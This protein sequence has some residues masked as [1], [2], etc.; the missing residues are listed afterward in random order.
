MRLNGKTALV[1]A[2]GAGIGRASARAFHAEG[3]QVWAIDI[4]AGALESLAAETPGLRTRQ[5]D[6]RESAAL[7]A[8]AAEIGSCDV[9]LNAVGVVQGGSVLETKI[10]DLAFG[11]D[12]NVLTM[13][14]TIQAFL[15]AMLAKGSGAIVNIAS[16]A[17]S[18]TGVPNRFAYGVT[19][20]AVIG[21]TKSVAA[22][23]VKQGVR[24]NAVC[25]GTIDTP[26]LRA[27][28]AAQGDPEAALK[29]FVARQPMGR[30]GRAEEI[31]AMALYLASD[32]AA[33]VTGQAFAIDGG[34]TT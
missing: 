2:A 24:C 19:K 6:A 23:F 34:W 13:A 22:D 17:S 9:L 11:F 32:E 14:R 8:L 3:A 5:L 26:S 29:A 28:A 4:D 33:F 31:A 18:I 21:L 7:A 1:T 16:V 25:P 15:P 20:A 30:L 27:R 12:M 10:E